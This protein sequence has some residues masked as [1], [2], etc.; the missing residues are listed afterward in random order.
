MSQISAAVHWELTVKVELS[1]SRCHEAALGIF[2][3]HGASERLA[4][5]NKLYHTLTTAARSMPW[6]LSFRWLSLEIKQMYMLQL[7]SSNYSVSH[8][9]KHCCIFVLWRWV[10]NLRTHHAQYAEVNEWFWTHSLTF[11]HPTLL[12]GWEQFQGFPRRAL[13]ADM[14]E[15][16]LKEK[17]KRC[18]SPSTRPSGCLDRLSQKLHCT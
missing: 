15:R 7:V 2:Q 17:W 8:F 13:K 12:W 18:S 4:S 16:A 5:G 10:H 14:F 11:G 3:Q 6:Y 9:R 1:H